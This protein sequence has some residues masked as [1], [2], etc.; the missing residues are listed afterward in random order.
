MDEDL[1]SL[2]IKI[3]MGYRYDKDAIALNNRTKI[4]FSDLMRNMKRAGMESIDI[5]SQR[6]GDRS[7]TTS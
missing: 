7:P 3:P 2:I 4:I 6:S 1:I 5:L